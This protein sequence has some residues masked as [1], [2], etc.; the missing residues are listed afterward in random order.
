MKEYIH[1]NE[2][3]S[4][5]KWH[6]KQQFYGKAFVISRRSIIALIVF[7]CLITPFT[8]WAIPLISKVIK[9][10]IKITW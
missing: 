9:S 7:I 2:F 1:W 10:G 3:N 6:D 8:N 5:S 4:L